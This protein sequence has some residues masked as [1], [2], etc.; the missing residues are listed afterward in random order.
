MQQYARMDLG[1]R[2]KGVIMIKV[3]NPNKAVSQ[4]IDLLN[5]E[6]LSP[7]FSSP[8]IEVNFS[9]KGKDFTF[10]IHDNWVNVG[11]IDKPASVGSAR[12]LVEMERIVSYIKNKLKE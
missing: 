10:T 3:K 5:K 1:V 12:D 8:T 9:V 2:K 7:S 11:T 6:N 4:L